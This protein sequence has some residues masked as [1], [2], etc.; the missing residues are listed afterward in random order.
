MAA[1]EPV[2]EHSILVAVKAHFERRLESAACG[3]YFE[4]SSHDLR[5]WVRRDKTAKAEIVFH[6]QYLSDRALYGTTARA[7]AC[8]GGK[9]GEGYF[10]PGRTYASAVFVYSLS[11]WE[12]GWHIDRVE[13]GPGVTSP[14]PPPAAEQLA[15][16]PGS[17]L[18]AR[19]LY[20]RGVTHFARG[21]YGR[22]I[23]DYTAAIAADPSMTLA[24][25][26]RCLARVIAGQDL[27]GARADCRE[28]LA[29]LPN[30]PQVRETQGLVR[31][32]LNDPRSAVVEYDAALK[33]DPRRAVALFGRGVAK[34]R[35]GNSKGAAVDKAA[36]LAVDPQVERTFGGYG[37]H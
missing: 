15:P 37:V 27:P 18:G 25:N 36:A 16:E 34:A 19:E 31:L 3:G 2:L 29:R 20:N 12:M 11:L 35:L 8:L 24:Y 6:A 32:L 13:F 14:G 30:D 21:D 10:V 9:A 17:P 4:L 33:I 28:A 1:G 26:N 5:N 23:A 22:A 7:V